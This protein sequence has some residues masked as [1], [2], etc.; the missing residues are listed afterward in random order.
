MNNS[1]NYRFETGATVTLK[2]GDVDLGDQVTILKQVPNY[3]SI[4]TNEIGYYDLDVSAYTEEELNKPFY[5]GEF[6]GDEEWYSES[7]FK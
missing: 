3:N 7:E 5:K 4:P 2:H 1:K 6:A